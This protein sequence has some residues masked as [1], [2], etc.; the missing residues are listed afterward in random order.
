MLRFT[1]DTRLEEYEAIIAVSLSA[2]AKEFDASNKT[3]RDVSSIFIV[4]IFYFQ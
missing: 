4:E 3:R 1:N 2:C